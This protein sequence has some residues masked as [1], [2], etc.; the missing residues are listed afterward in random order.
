MACVSGSQVK[1]S[2]RWRPVQYHL[3]SSR[4]TGK[5]K[6]PRPGTNTSCRKRCLHGTGLPRMLGSQAASF[7][8]RVTLTLKCA[9]TYS[10]RSETSWPIRRSQRGP[11]RYASPLLLGDRHGV[12][13]RR[14][15]TSAASAGASEFGDRFQRF[16]SAARCTASFGSAMGSALPASV[17]TVETH[18][19]ADIRRRGPSSIPSLT[20][21][22]K[23]KRLID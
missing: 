2:G 14:R 18:D 17:A 6:S 19:L 11:Y 16:R 22:K 3:C 10:S 23:Q 15:T 12:D 21:S 20:T 4:T 1:T 7:R 13:E 5:A 9:G 8:R